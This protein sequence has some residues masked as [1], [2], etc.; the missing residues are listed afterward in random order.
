[1]KVSRLI[2]IFGACA[3]V[4]C[5]PSAEAAQVV[6]WDMFGQPGNQVTTPSTSS[7]AN[8]TGK[9]FTRGPGLNPNSGNNSFN[10]NGFESTTQGAASDEFLEFGFTVDPGFFVDL[11]ELIIGTRSSNTGPG[12]LG[13]Y[14]SLDGFT[15]PVFTFVQSGTNF[16]NSTIDLSGLPSITGDFTARIIEI[17]NTQADGDG[18]N[19]GSGTF[20]VVDFFDDGNFIDTQFTGSVAVVPE[21]STCILMVIGLCGAVAAFRRRAAA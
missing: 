13:L 4:A 21:P 1:M 9:A 6:A 2:L 7:A 12:M 11:D 14:T 17:G 8:V 19:S 10:S 16:L 3:A 15:S 18:A 20:R 5:V